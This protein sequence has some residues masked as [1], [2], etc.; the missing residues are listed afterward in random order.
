MYTRPMPKIALHMTGGGARGAYQAG[1]LKAVAEIL[2][3]RTLPFSLISGTSVGSLN[4]A[5]LCEYADDFI[6]GVEKIVHLWENIH[7][8]DIFYAQ[9][10]TLGRSLLRNL[11]HFFIVKPR[12]TH[13]LDTQPLAHYLEQ[14]I[15][16]DKIN[17]NIRNGSVETLEIIAHCYESQKTISFYQQKP[18][19]DDWHYPKHIS[20]QTDLNIKHILAST[21]IPFFFS[22]TFIE[23]AH[24][25]DGSIGLISPLRGALRFKADKIFVISTRHLLN[26]EDVE[27]L[28]GKDIGFAHVLGSLLNGMFIDNLDRDL[29]LV[30]RMNDIIEKM[31]RWKKRNS[32]WRYVET[33]HMRPSVNI[34]KIA[35]ADYHILPKLLKV[36]LNLLG[37]QSGELLSFLLFEPT[38]TKELLNLG[39]EDTMLSADIVQAFFKDKL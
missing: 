8:D 13:L 1:V 16:F 37:T 5:I 2:N 7:C 28:R 23:N 18:K 34:S 26:A 15:N 11:A 20:S 38:F 33:L 24:Y 25:G 21:A 9:N 10:Y 3:T 22:P 36:L 29:E 27:K 32:T 31:S 17:Q 12:P 6:L 35:Q 14:N 30:S 19:F 39:Y 4:A